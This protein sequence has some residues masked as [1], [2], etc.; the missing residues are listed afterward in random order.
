MR[1]I[2]PDEEEEIPA[3]ATQS[4][5]RTTMALPMSPDE[6]SEAPRSGRASVFPAMEGHSSPKGTAEP[7]AEM[8]LK[9]RQTAF[10]DKELLRLATEGID[11]NDEEEDATTPAVFTFPSLRVGID[12]LTKTIPPDSIPVKEDEETETACGQACKVTCSL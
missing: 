11:A 9:K 4:R 1:E 10:V 8:R 5:C 7:A 6:P 12:E 2:S 3:S